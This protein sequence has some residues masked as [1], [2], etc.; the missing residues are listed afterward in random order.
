MRL[1]LLLLAACTGASGPAGTSGSAWVYTDTAGVPHVFARSERDAFFLQGWLAGRDRLFQMDLT[2]RRAQGRRAE[3]LGEDRYTSDVQARALRFADWGTRTAAML[4][5]T[6]PRVAE[7]VQAYADGVNAWIDDAVNGRDGASLPPQIEALGYVPE[8]WTPADSMAIEKMI[9]A[10]LSMRPDQE[11]TLGLLRLLVGAELFHDL[12]VYEPF[13]DD[14]IAA[15]WLDEAAAAG[16]LDEEVPAAGTAQPPP[17][18]LDEIDLDKLR[19]ALAELNLSYGGSN[20]QAIDAAHSATGHA[21]LLGDSHQ[22]VTHPATYWLVHL[23][24]KDKGGTLDV[25]GASFP[26]APLVMFGTNG[27]IAWTPTTSLLDVSDV[28]LET[29]ADAEQTAVLHDGEAVPVEWRDEVFLVRTDAGL[30]ERTVPLADVPHHGPILPAEALGLPLPITASIGWTGYQARSTAS[31]YLRLAEAADVDAGLAAFDGYFTGGQ[32]W[33]I[34]DTA[35]RIAWTAEVDLPTRQQLDP[36]TPPLVL[37]PG[38]GG[39]DWVPGDGVPYV[40]TAAGHALQRVDP[41]DGFLVSANNDPVGQTLDG[42]PF[43][44]GTYLSAVFDIGTR[45]YQPRRRLTELLASGPVSLDAARDVQLDTHSRLADVLLPYLFAAADR[46]PD[47]VTPEL[48][49]LLTRL[50]GW[51]H[52]CGVAQVEPSIFHLWLMLAARDLMADEAGGLVGDLVFEDMSY[53]LGLVAVKFM[54]HWLQRTEADL[55]RI[56]A[57]ELPFPS[58]SGLNLFDRRDTEAVETRDEVL[59]GALAAAISEA[60]EIFGS[61]DPAAWLWGTWHQMALVDPADALV[62]EASAAPQPKAGGL[63]TVDVGDFSWF[64][65]GEVPDVLLV[66]NAPSNRFVFDLDPA[67][68]T[69]LIALP[70]GQ[71]ERPGALHH[72]DLFAGYLAGEYVTLPLGRRAVELAAEDELYVEGR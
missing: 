33:L 19:A 48:D 70:G 39:Y 8:P 56:E 62:P 45:S 2:R 1:S 28:W 29:W 47:L 20:N 26:G 66:T 52:A 13:D 15:G 4:P 9:T 69:A 7:I 34:G 30:E 43:N 32:N 27:Q 46:R 38:T 24:T 63:Y 50:R 22:G 44:D 21:L 64:V 35:G 58:R 3:L 54:R 11:I 59:L 18:G 55:D 10:G 60:T 53:Q 31:T 12:Y 57:G 68:V 37:L 14:V 23:N 6:D 16:L 71:D 67:G 51:D 40:P 72:N 61:A 17:P 25:A 41:T 5:A 42:D 36:A 65:E 49:D